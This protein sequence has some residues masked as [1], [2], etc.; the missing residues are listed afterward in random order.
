MTARRRKWWGIDAAVRQRST[1]AAARGGHPGRRSSAGDLERLAAE[2][3]ARVRAGQ[4][5]IKH[6]RPAPIPAA[7]A[8]TI[9]AFVL[10]WD[11]FAEEAAAWPRAASRFALCGQKRR[12]H[13][14]ATVAAPSSAIASRRCPC[15]LSLA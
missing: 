7:G 4:K 14:A 6:P 11:G 10:I 5:C 1:Q 12:S 9:L 13:G 8:M 2:A 3:L 15:P